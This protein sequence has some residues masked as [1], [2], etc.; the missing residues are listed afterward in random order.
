MR[1]YVTY[2][3]G[4]I[5]K[6][7]SRYVYYVISIP[8]LLFRSFAFNVSYTIYVFQYIHIRTLNTQRNILHDVYIT[9]GV[10]E[11]YDNLL[12]MSLPSRNMNLLNV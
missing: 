9:W 10:V 2:T 11:M 6:T 12:E 3:P 8:G 4:G 7:R 1:L 5:I